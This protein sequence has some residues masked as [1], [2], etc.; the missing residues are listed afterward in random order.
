MTPRE[1]ENLAPGAPDFRF[2]EHDTVGSTNSLCFDRAAAGHP[3]NLWIRAEVQSEGRGR[4]GR[5][6]SSPRGNLFASLL[7]IDPQPADRIGELPLAAAVALADA[8]DNATGAH[9]LVD[10][11]WPNDLLVG[12]AKLSG[13]LLEA[14]TLSDGR[15][16]VVIGFGV[17]CV[18]HPPLTLY[19]A[20]DLRSLGYQVV[21][22]RLFEALLPAMSDYLGQWK[23]PGG[24]QTIRR[25]WLKRAA[26][27]GKEISVRTAQDEITGVFAD[28]D[29][30][31]HLVLKQDDGRQRTIYAGDVFLSGA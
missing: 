20:T 28:L 5:D 31:G 30:R 14:E 15:Q 17:N 18:S 27:L 4:R 29:E 9:Q 3:G 1:T 26:H 21:A 12:G 24:F 8:V 10:L 23:Q 25:Q 11:K 7:L 2:E 6:W 13:I 16:A 22:D 19:Q